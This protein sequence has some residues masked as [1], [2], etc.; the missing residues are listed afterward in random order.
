MTNDLFLLNT[1]SVY[2]HTCGPLGCVAMFTMQATEANNN[3][4]RKIHICVEVKT[5][6]TKVF[7]Y[8]T[9]I[10]TYSNQNHL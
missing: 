8:Q 6:F 2:T 10:H 4:K 1:G 9:D 3:K 5:L 7:G